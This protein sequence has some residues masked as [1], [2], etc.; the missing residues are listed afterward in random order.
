MPSRCP[1]RGE[2]ALPLQLPYVGI[3]ERPVFT[4]GVG[5]QWSQQLPQVAF[6]DLPGKFA[7]LAQNLGWSI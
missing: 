4:K 6:E 3:R 1:E 7:K 2:V 5:M